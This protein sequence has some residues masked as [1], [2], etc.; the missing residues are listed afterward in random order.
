MKEEE[1]SQASIRKA[2]WSWGIK[3]DPERMVG[4]REKDKRDIVIR[5]REIGKYSV[6]L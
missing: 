2:Y 1:R 3:E 5:S 6:F 4:F